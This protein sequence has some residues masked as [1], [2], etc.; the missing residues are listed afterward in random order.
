MPVKR[1]LKRKASPVKTDYGNYQMNSA[2]GNLAANKV[3]EQ[4]GNK[5]L[6]RFQDYPIRHA[7]NPLEPKSREIGEGLNHLHHYH[8]VVRSPTIDG[9][10]F[11]KNLGAGG[12]ILPITHPALV[13]NGTSTNFL[14]R[15]FLPPEYANYIK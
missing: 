11:H 4:T 14:M 3:L 8:H 6:Q 2:Y 15:H 7:K 10:G 1:N 9:S 13:S 12:N 5:T